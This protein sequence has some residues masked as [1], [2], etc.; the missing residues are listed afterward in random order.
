[1][2]TCDSILTYVLSRSLRG[3][4][5]NILLGHGVGMPMVWAQVGPE[6]RGRAEA[7]PRL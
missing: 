3:C 5:K 2:L 7:M 4:G 6:N 1:M